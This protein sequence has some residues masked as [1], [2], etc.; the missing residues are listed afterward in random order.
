M[1]FIFPDEVK[2]ESIYEN[3]NGNVKENNKSNKEDKQEDTERENGDTSEFL[4]IFFWRYWV[5][6]KQFSYNYPE[7]IN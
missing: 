4:N 1:Y 6:T 2:N 3:Q 5:Y 7:L